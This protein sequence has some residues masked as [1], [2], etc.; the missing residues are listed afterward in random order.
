VTA[1]V[2]VRLFA[3]AKA[4]AGGLAVIDSDAGLTLAQT[5]DRLGGTL[6]PRFRDVARRCT[7]LVDG[8]RTPLDA[9]LVLTPGQTVDILPPFAGG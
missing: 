3:A 5:L 2:Q 6:G 8:L 7:C 9:P 1:P 4:A